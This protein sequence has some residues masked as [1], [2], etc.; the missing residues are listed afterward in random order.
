MKCFI[1]VILLIFFS[2]GILLSYKDSSQICIAAV[3]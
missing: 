3:Y 1:A 2:E